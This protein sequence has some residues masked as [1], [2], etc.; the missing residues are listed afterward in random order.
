MW[1]DIVAYR[2]KLC[3]ETFENLEEAEMH[4]VLHSDELLEEIDSDES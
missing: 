4:L 3:G 1:G 2:C